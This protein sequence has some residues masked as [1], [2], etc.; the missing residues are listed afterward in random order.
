MQNLY[1]D[2]NIFMLEFSI[3][4]PIYNILAYKFCT[5]II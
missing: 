3:L 5:I 2:N 1:M 4:E